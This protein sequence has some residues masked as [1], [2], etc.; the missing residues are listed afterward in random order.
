V[1]D[2]NGLTV[3]ESGALKADGSIAGNAND[4]DPT[5]FEPHLRR[6]TNSD[7]VEIYAPILGESVGHVTTGLLDAMRYL[8]DNR[9]LPYGFDKQTAQPDIA[10]IARGAHGCSRF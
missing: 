1:K 3:F 4:P 2:R 6:I 9:L 10:V 8:K 5:R 7:Q